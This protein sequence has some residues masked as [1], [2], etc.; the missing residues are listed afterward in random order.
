MKK[1][2]LLSIPSMIII[3]VIF[4]SF[5]VASLL[6][7]DFFG[8]DNTTN[9][10]DGNVIINQ[11]YVVNNLPYAKKY[12]SAVNKNL[13]N[14]Y[15]PLDRIL[16]FYSA[17]NKLSFDKIYQDN[18]ENKRLKPISKVCELED[19]KKLL[20]CE[21]PKVSEDGAK[22][23]SKPLD[24][25][26]VTVTS[27]F[28]EQRKV[29]NVSDVHPAW[30]LAIGAGTPVYAVCDGKIDKV[31]FPY[32]QNTTNKSGGRGNYITLKCNVNGEELSVIYGHLYPN[33]NK[34][35]VGDMVGRGTQIASVGTTGYST[36]NH[37]H[38]EVQ[39]KNKTKIDG[40]SLIN[41]S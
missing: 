36:G 16:Y 10:E 15:V 39:K 13:Q 27:F 2:L 37:L 19:Y 22:P 28:M 17:N 9:Y 41:F 33:S 32:T 38:F 25:S 30:D 34:V 40:M 7:L 4:I 14:G 11:N 18:L 29:F 26:G 3:I 24:F 8:E 23:F 1:I 35:S 6:T 12:K 31:V 5:I 21:N 20:V